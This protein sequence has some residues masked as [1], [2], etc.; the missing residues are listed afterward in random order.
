MIEGLP[1]NIPRD[2]RLPRR[3]QPNPAD[4]F[5]LV[6]HNLCDATLSQPA[7][8][9]WP[10]DE[11]HQSRAFWSAAKDHPGEQ[12]DLDP[13][14]AKDLLELAAVLETYPQYSRAVAFMRSL[15]GPRPRKNASALEFI[16]AGGNAPRHD[17]PA[18]L[19]DRP[20]RPD[21]Y[22]MQVRFHRP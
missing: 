8:L 19:P 1:G 4:V 15:A 18:R 14:R 21:P 12:S 6:K 17:I 7:L 11:L 22:R 13:E 16:A 2:E 10:G 3:Y 20:D 9:V 5:C